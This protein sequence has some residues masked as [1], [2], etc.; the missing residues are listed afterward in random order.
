MFDDRTN[1]RH[2][3][4]SVCVKY[5]FFFLV[6]CSWVYRHYHRYPMRFTKFFFY[7]SWITFL[8]FGFTF[9]DR[10][11][12][13][14]MGLFGRY[15]V[16]NKFQ[17][18]DLLINRY[19]FVVVIVVCYS[20]MNSHIRPCYTFISLIILNSANYG[21]EISEQ[22]IRFEKKRN[23]KLIRIAISRIDINRQI[24]NAVQQ[25]HN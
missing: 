2:S 12:F 3:A 9:C 4:L 16:I 21:I 24:W 7:H 20:W 6:V 17:R 10:F 18:F 15:F 13:R 14:P 11:V 22:I 8:S 5:I 23:E 1:K 19:G 25:H